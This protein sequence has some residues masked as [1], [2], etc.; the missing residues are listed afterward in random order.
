MSNLTVDKTSRKSK[1]KQ[2][3]FQ[4]LWDKADR[5]KRQN[6][7]LKSRLDELIEIAEQKIR[8]VEREAAEADLPLLRKLLTLGQRKSMAKWKRGVLDDWIR[9]LITDMQILGITDITLRDEIA[10]YDAFRLGVELDVTPDGADSNSP[11]EQM[12]VYLQNLQQ[13]AEEIERQESVQADKEFENSNDSI[14][15]LIE[16]ELDKRLG[17]PPS[18]PDKHQR[19]FDLLQ[20]EL[21]AELDAQ[22]M[23]YH[24]RR[25]V[26]RDELLAELKEEAARE[27]GH[28]LFDDILDGA[29]N[30][31][32]F[33]AEDEPRDDRTDRTGQIDNETF[34]RMFRSTAARL[35]P[36]REPDP[37][38]REEKQKLLVVLL[39]ARKKGDL[40]TVL[41]MYKEHT[42]NRESLTAT[43][44]KQ[45]IE[46][47][48][49]HIDQ[50]ELEKEELVFQSPAHYSVYTLFFHHSKKKQSKKISD[51]IRGIR[52][53]MRKSEK[54]RDTIK[55]LKTLE[56]WLEDRY[57]AALVT[58]FGSEFDVMFNGA[59]PRDCPF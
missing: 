43:D 9:D 20:D 17:E 26:L 8:P 53:N 6:E 45:L 28:E 11:Y 42:D 38:K 15:D 3:R 4:K 36:D 21:D 49:Y 57:E 25:D 23:E 59:E 41:R 29:F 27:F 50:L 16:K 7:Q 5:L 58:D 13:E 32:D 54:M 48:E 2:S 24:R 34:L 18:Q 10:R 44:E 40:L 46:S 22:L 47:M 39:N 19:T 12:S 37:K 35:H 51:H 55:S 33:D 52:K 14:N 31:F 1:K 56:P 30:G